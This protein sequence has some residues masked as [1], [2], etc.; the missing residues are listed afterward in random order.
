MGITIKG[1]K[2][3]RT[4]LNNLGGDSNEAIGKGMKDTVLMAEATAKAKV[5]VS[6]YSQADSSGGGSLRGSIQ[7]EAKET[8]TGWEG[9]VYSNAPHASYV[10]F[11]TGP[12]GAA[13]NGGT[14]PKVRVSY[15]LRSFW[16]Y[17]TVIDGEQTFRRTSG[18]PARPFMYPTAVEHKD[19]LSE[20]LRHEFVS[21]M[22]RIAK[23][24]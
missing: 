7:S 11:G 24:G 14:S 2:G 21:A 9:R 13:N 8:A 5:P 19:T 22:R 18:Q 4:K 15:T 10:E 16:T 17:P 6:K 23:G 20:R 3:L 1:L 12:V